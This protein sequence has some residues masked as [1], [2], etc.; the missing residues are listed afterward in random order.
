MFLLRK[1]CKTRSQGMTLVEILLVVV[2]SSMLSIAAYN[3]LLSGLRIW[4]R[5]Q[6]LVVE[7]DVVI[8]FDKITKDLQNT[9]YYSRIIA[10]GNEQRFAFPSRVTTL[11]DK[12]RGL[13]QGAYVEQ[14]GQ[15]EYYFDGATQSLYRRQANYAQALNGDFGEARVLVHGVDR[16]KFR[17]IYLTEDGEIFSDEVLDLLPSS[18]DVEIFL[19]KKSEEKLLKKLI[20]IPLTL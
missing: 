19:N 9:F 14:I 15:V 16:L 18:V 10:T 7:E 4:E 17:Y 13:S 6:R 3:L 12:K 8:F 2:L 1:Q 11:A 20:N 5:A